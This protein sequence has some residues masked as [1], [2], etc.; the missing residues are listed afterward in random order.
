MRRRTKVTELIQQREGLGGEIV[1]LF[2]S[3]NTGM[4]H[5]DNGFDVTFNEESLV[6]GLS[7]SELSL[8]QKVSYGL[9]FATGAKVPT[10]I[11]VH[12]ESGAQPGTTEESEDSVSAKASLGEVGWLREWSRLENGPLAFSVRRAGLRE[13]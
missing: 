9:F 6:V 11:N 3:R 1:Q 5:G 7:Y 2:Y 10:A 12:A 8:G 13:C 4:I